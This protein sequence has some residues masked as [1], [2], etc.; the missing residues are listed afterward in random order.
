[1]E[2]DVSIET[3][4]MIRVAVLPIGSISIPLF[5]DYTSMLVPHYTVSLSSISSFY[6]EH[7]KSPFANQPWDSGSLRFKYM[8]GG[9]PASP[10]E[11]FQSNRKIFAVIGI[12]HCPTSPDLHSVM[13]QF[14]NACKSYSSSVVQRCFA[15]C[16][17]DSQLEDESFKGSNL[18]LFPP[19]DRQTQEFHLQT[20]LQDIAASLLMEFE[21]S[22][23]QAESGGTILKT[24]LDSQASLSSEEVIKAKKRRLGR[25][26]K[27]IGDYC[28]LAGSPVDANA[29]YSTSLELARLTGDFFW[30]AGAM[31]GSV[32]ALLIDQM[33]QRDQV[34]D[35]EVKYRY[36]NVILHYRKSFIQDNAQ[37]VSPL[38]FELEATLKLARF[39]CRKEL[40]KEVVDLLTAAADGAKSLIDASDRLIL[41]I[42]IARLFG[43]LGYHRK[44]AFFSRQVAQ[45]YL[46]QENQLAAISSMQ[47]LAMTTQAYRV[48]SR[49]STDHALYQE[50]GQNH[51]DGGKAHHNW[52]VS[53]F[54][55]QWSSIQ[56]VVLREI[57]LSAVRGG[58][59]LTAW[60]AAARLLRS[61]YPLITPA[62][63]NGLASALSNASERLPSGTRCADP[64]LPFI[65]LHSFPLHSSQQDIV[66]RNHGR[67]DWWA[68]SAPSGPFI[69]TPFSKGEPNQS[70]KQELIWIVG[71]AVQVF[72]ELANPCGFDL[73]VDSIYLSVNSG[74]FD[75]FPI[76]VNLPPN[77]SKVIALSGI[78]TEVGPLKIPGCIVHCFG[79]I[80]EHYFKDVDNLLVGAAQGLVLSDPFRCCGSPKLKNVT[81][82]NISVVPP[83]PLLISRVVGSDGAI[84]LYEGEIRE[85]QISLANAGTVPIEQAHISLSGK[86]QDSIQSI[87]YETLQSS[88]PLKPGAEVRIP[89]TLKAW[90]LGLL[91]PDAGPS[92]NISGS[93]GRQV[94]DGCSPLL[95]IHYAGPLAYAV[96]ASTNGSIPPGRRLVVPL[97]ICVSQGLSLMKAR[98]LSMEIPALVAEN[99]SKVQVETCSAEGSPRTDRFMK[100]DPY[101]GS[102]GL[103]FLELELSNPTDVVFEIGV[104]V[105]MED[106]NNE[107]NP[108]Y[109]YP[110]TRIDRD[111]TARVLIPLEHFKLPVLDGTFLVKDSQMNG[112]ASRRSSFSEKS[113]KAELNASIKNLI[114]KIKV[115]WQSGRN[116]SGELNIKDAIQAAL[117]SSVMDVLLPDPL[118]FGF[119]CGNNTSQDFA[120][121]KLDEESD[122]Q[123]ARK[124][125][126]KAHDT[127]PVEVLVRNNTKEMIKVSLS[128]TCK[129]IA[130]ENCVEGD[131]A[132]VL[133]AGVLSG[134]TLEVPPLKE[135]RH[136]FSLYFLVPGEYTLLAAAV[137]DDAN[138]MLR[139]RARANTCDESIFCR[140]PPFHIRVNGTM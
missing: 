57:L 97:N 92:K 98:L 24:P 4:C 121:H 33:G 96:D 81:V 27:T 89:V 19:A 124:G 38:S 23:L 101:R 18:I 49:A 2:P 20:M 39:L 94:K 120:E 100:I 95:L 131:K 78:P 15:F 68:G 30:F 103:R 5:R 139:A 84:I 64:A 102:W 129:D 71:E 83:L 135:Y 62:G 105:N 7:Q 79:V 118:T 40:A 114:S 136:S 55:S 82:P 111:Y 108:E 99:H 125:S 8:V 134:V 90:Q 67:D 123:G 104:S 22:V 77:S 10:W 80:T 110:K 88:L 47:V 85:V 63:Q 13:D 3:S 42:E 76:S 48:Q 56:M 45:L 86:N 31:E 93:T 21:K 37:R 106:S 35:D 60:S 65:R 9:S 112:T 44:A 29:H 41:Y 130:G 36:N 66:K 69:Y 109:D 52:I 25:A 132:T 91:D 122:A 17:G 26:Q 1:M 32:C 6:T 11:D 61:Y 34:L 140:G 16:P 51:A 74:N 72:V 115:G 128:I 14:A 73:K 137:I 50:S 107:E 28:L 59:P 87:A 113:S 138:E 117:Q 127:I 43:T 75:A 126:V 133:W 119:R 46:Q 54:E 70:S 58:D 12:C 116:N 53:L